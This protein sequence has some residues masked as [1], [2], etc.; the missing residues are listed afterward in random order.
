MPVQSWYE[1]IG[2]ETISDSIL[3]SLPHS[4]YRIELTRDFLRKKM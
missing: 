2:E 1:V 3:D 4:S